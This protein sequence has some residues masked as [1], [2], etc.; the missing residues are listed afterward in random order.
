MYYMFNKMNQ[1]V[2]Q[3]LTIDPYIALNGNRVILRVL[4]DYP[5]YLLISHSILQ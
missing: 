2:V 3:V 4:T 1:F 5:N